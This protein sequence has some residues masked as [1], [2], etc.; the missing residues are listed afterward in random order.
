MLGL[1]P[2]RFAALGGGAQQLVPPEIAAGLHVDTVTGALVYD[3]LLD[4]LAALCQGFVRDL[5]ERHDVA[6]T[7]AAVGGD[8]QARA[9]VLD[10]VLQRAGGE[11][12]EHHRVDR[13]DAGAGLHGDDRF[14]CHRHVDHH[15][16]TL[17]DALGLEHVGELADLGVELLVGVIAGVALF[18][19]EADR[20]LVAAGQQVSV[21]AVG[22]SIELA[23]GEPA[24]VRCGAVV[25]NLGERRLPAEVLAGQVG[26]EAVVVGLRF[27]VQGREFLGVQP[28]ASGEVRRRRERSGF[29]KDGCDVVGTHACLRRAGFLMIR[30][31]AKTPGG[32]L[33]ARR[34]PGVYRLCC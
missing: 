21:Q 10:A 17:G 20:D 29:G 22:G 12:A 19:F 26:P 9:G 25:Q 14:G 23:V 18:A 34:P 8:Q 13:A 31:P 33:M 6:G 28:G 1:D 5:L 30:V 24:V 32:F 16:V 4:G 15:A 2:F 7:V 27:G 11:T 3:D